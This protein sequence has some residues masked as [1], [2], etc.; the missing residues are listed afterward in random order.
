[1]KKIQKPISI[2][3]A[4][5]LFVYG[6]VFY[7][8]ICF[9]EDKVKTTISGISSNI[10]ALSSKELSYSVEIEPCNKSRIVLLQLYNSNEKQYTT[11]NRYVT[12]KAQV[13][14]VKITFPKE[15]RK[16]T[17]GKW[18]LLVLEDKICEKAEM[19]ITVTSKN[20]VNKDISSKAVCIYCV[21]DKKIIYEKQPHKKL[22]QASTTK[23]MTALLLLESGKIN[24]SVKISSKAAKTEYSTPVM[25]KDDIYTNIALLHAMMLP[26]SNGAA[27]AVAESV[28]S[29]T[30]E[31][32]KLMNKKASE[33][34]LKDTHY[35]CVHGLDTKEH[36]SSAY[37]VSVLTGYT[38]KKSD[39]FRKL[40]AKDKYRI[41]SK[42]SKAVT[43]YTTDKLNGYSEK[44]KGGKT[45][46]TTGA[47]YCFSGVYVHKGKTYVACVLG[48]KTGKERWKDMKTLYK[49]IDKY[50][51]TEY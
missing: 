7:S 20:I 48:A 2:L 51:A 8:S 24:D 5:I 41:K 18:R 38:Y 14:S 15:Y 46:H 49:Y 31:F 44:H 37:D 50:A 32:I 42:K 27:V 22:K 25:K 4:V 13:A 10:S 16:K 40:I 33:L 6:T 39:T 29:S 19:L 3:L 11:I 26:S 45:G 28:S 47:G 17:I 1:M 34:G 21:E 9:S 43:I 30:G 12:Q 36:Y 35:A 23:V